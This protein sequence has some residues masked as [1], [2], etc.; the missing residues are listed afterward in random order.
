VRASNLWDEITSYYRRETLSHMTMILMM[1]TMTMM[2]MTMM[3]MM[4]MMTMMT[5]PQHAAAGRWVSEGETEAACSPRVH[6]LPAW[7]A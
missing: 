6:T 3:M 1:M 7:T 4:M 2:M 5:D